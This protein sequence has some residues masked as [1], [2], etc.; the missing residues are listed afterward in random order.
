MGYLDLAL[1]YSNQTPTVEAPASGGGLRSFISTQFSIH[2]NCLNST[3]NLLVLRMQSV[4]S[5]VGFDFC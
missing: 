4:N 3:F 2:F 5:Y 1:S